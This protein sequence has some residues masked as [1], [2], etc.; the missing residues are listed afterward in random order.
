[1][2]MINKIFLNKIFYFRIVLDLH[3]PTEFPYIPHLVSFHFT[4]VTINK[5]S[6][7]LYGRVFPQSSARKEICPFF[8]VTPS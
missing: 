6:S 3:K 8:T 2:I 4:F 5:P 1:M 7:T